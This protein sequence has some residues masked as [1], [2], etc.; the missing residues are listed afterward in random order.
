MQLWIYSGEGIVGWRKSRSSWYIFCAEVLGAMCYSSMIGM[1]GWLVTNAV[2]CDAIFRWAAGC[3]AVMSMPLHVVSGL[4][5]SLP[6]SVLGWLG[7]DV[8]VPYGAAGSVV[9][10]M[11][12]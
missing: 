6:I 3:D 5:I 1:F 8:N 12:Q 4:F 11:S 9:R 2:L 10:V 7:A